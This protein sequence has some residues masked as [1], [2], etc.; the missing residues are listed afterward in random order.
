[1]KHI[2]LAVL[3]ASMLMFPA[4]GGG[5]SKMNGGGTNSK[6][7]DPSGNW[8]MTAQDQQG[9]KV[10][11]AALFNQVGSIVTANSFTATGNPS[12]FNCVPF[13]ATLS[14]GLVQNVSN[15]TG[16]VNL[17]FDVNFPTDTNKTT[18]VFSFD[19]TLNQ[20]GTSFSGTYSG[21]PACAAVAASGTITGDEVPPVDGNWTGTIQACAHDGQTG[22][23][24][25]SGATSA[26]SFTLAQN[27]ATGNVTGTYQVANLPGMSNGVVAVVPPSDLLSGLN[28]QATMTDLNGAKFILAGGP[29]N[30]QPG[31]GLDRT[32]K[33]LLI[34]NQSFYFVSISH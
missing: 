3:C 15:F 7:I 29:F 22:A 10:L 17:T 19:T 23:C 33:G 25:V 26:I 28:L 14:N 13:Q 18:G 6:V 24:P 9:R 21:M 34:S 31:L 2:Y 16:V 11:F 12:P 30:R 27:D 20:A 32:F 5:G 8:T 4:C 1:M